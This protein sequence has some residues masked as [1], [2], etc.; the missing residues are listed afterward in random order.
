MEACYSAEATAYLRPFESKIQTYS[1][2]VVEA[3]YESLMLEENAAQVLG[4]LSIT[5]MNHLRE[6]QMKY[7]QRIL[8]PDLKRED[9]QEMAYQAGLRHERVGLFPQTLAGSFQVYRRVLEEHL[10]GTIQERVALRGL[11]MERL[12]NDLTM[13]L[14]AYTKAEQDRFMAMQ[15]LLGLCQMARRV[16]DLLETTVS[17]IHGIDGIRAALIGNMN[18]SG[19]FVVEASGGSFLRCPANHG[20]RS[21]LEEIYQKAW[22]SE[23]LIV[24]D[25]IYRD[26]SC[27]TLLAEAQRLGVRS[28][29]VWPILDR[30]GSSAS[31]LVLNSFW[32][33]FFAQPTKQSFWSS[34]SNHIADALVN[35][36]SK[37]T[38][39]PLR[40]IA[41]NERQHIRYLLQNNG[42]EMFYQPIMDPATGQ[43]GKVESLARLRDGANILSPGHFLPTLGS[44]QLLHLFDLG[45]QQAIVA[46]KNLDELGFS[47]DMSINLPTEAFV[48]EQ[49]LEQLPLRVQELAGDPRRLTLEILETG[50]LDEMA[51]HQKIKDLQGIGFRFALD[52][53]GTG[54]SSFG[55]L[56]TLPVNQIKIDQQF[57]FPL[58]EHDENFEFILVLMNLAEDLGLDCV[59]EGVETENI[60]DM[61]GSL[62]MGFVQG[63]A[64]AKPMPFD[65]LV[66][67]LHASEDRMGTAKPHPHTLLGFYAQHVLRAKAIRNGLI[68]DVEMWDIEKLGDI[69]N[70]PF[71]EVIHRLSQG[72]T[73]LEIAHVHFHQAMVRVVGQVVVGHQD[74]RAAYAPLSMAQQVLREAIQPFL[75]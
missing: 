61:I 26:I 10:P 25:A 11:V 34:V 27:Q 3:F 1:V 40:V 41:Q 5:E 56:K 73:S 60:L 44:Q 54:E 71:T 69:Q 19:H 74:R 36:T 21:C 35:V 28:L 8:S 72:Q 14:M 65:E 32:P 59:V 33:G 9:H 52:D 16:G 30:V 64:I 23:Q 37:R 58:E 51:A 22:E 42:L 48:Q 70:C 18:P 67:W 53:V 13:Q 38:S 46:M 15:S 4:R 7:V 45:L 29:A 43:I 63:Y 55:R 6:S 66:Q 12:S 47:I 17:A 68:T 62:K 39:G 31:L 2:D 50:L 57:V 75:S 24:V 20:K 49:F